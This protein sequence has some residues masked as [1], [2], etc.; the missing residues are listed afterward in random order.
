MNNF[1]NFLSRAKRGRSLEI[2]YRDLFKNAWHPICI[3]L[4]PHSPLHTSEARNL[5]IGINNPYI[6]GSKVTDQI[7]YILP[8]SWNIKVQSFIFMAS[9]GS[10]ILKLVSKAS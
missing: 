5:K 1:S 8:R 6:D 3:C 4:S 10:I 7:F 2:L 9:I